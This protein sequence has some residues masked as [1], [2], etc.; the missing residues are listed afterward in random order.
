MDTRTCSKCKKA[1]PIDE[2][3]K[4][5]K[6]KIDSHCK[7]CRREAGRIRNKTEK[8]KA[9]NKKHYER[10]KESG[11]YAEYSKRPDV[12]KR[13]AE[14][15]QKYS[16]DPALAIKHMARRIVRNNKRNEVI[17]QQPCV[18]CGKEQTEAH[19]LDYDRP[20]LIVWMCPDCHRTEHAKATN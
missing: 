10:L 5:T 2:F 19:H 16:N 17:N 8:R 15:M 1:K 11:Y 7:E 4:S 13:K 9:Y 18:M 20:L 3:Y 6:P 14:Q 12:R